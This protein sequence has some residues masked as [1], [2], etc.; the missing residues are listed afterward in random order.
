MIN[1][2]NFVKSLP[3]KK[4]I[5][6]LADGNSMFPAIRKGDKVT[7]RKERFT[8]IEVN[9]IIAFH[10]VNRK[11]IIVHRVVKKIK[12]K[13][14]DYLITKGDNNRGEDHW[15]VTRENFFGRIINIQKD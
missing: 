9:D 1:S 2:I 8:D 4:E 6:V 3:Q 14:E 12:E 5:I 15:I 13:K 11:N 7:I 10:I